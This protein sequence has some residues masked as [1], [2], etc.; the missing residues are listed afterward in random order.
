MYARDK[1]DQ[2]RA[3]GDKKHWVKQNFK[4]EKGLTKL[5]TFK[6]TKNKRQ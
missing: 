1:L 5:A 2:E 4:Y 6:L 3:Y